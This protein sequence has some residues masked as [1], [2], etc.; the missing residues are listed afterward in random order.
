MADNNQYHWATFS[1]AL[2]VGLMVFCGLRMQ[3]YELM[4]ISAEMHPAIAFF[5]SPFLYLLLAIIAFPTE[6]LL[7]RWIYKKV[8]YS[9]ISCFSIGFLYS[10][11]L[12]WWSFPEHWQ[13]FIV[14]N[15]LLL[16]PLVGLILKNRVSQNT[17]T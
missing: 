4:S 3:Y 6:Y 10:T 7:N 12:V 13:L 16:R 2:F 5:F 1:F 14:I 15:P 9:R 17:Y 11:L 8:I